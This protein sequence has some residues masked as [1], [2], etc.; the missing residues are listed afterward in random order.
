VTRAELCSA[1]WGTDTFVDYDAGLNTAVAKL[2]E[3]LEDDAEAPQFIDTVPKRGNGWTC[4][5]APLKTRAWRVSVTPSID[6][7]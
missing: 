6:A 7:A 4:D 2:R 3:A 1:L 5:R